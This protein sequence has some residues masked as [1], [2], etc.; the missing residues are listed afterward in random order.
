MD[1]KTS[2]IIQIVETSTSG[3]SNIGTSRYGETFV[4]YT[5]ASDTGTG[6]ILVQDQEGVE[7]VIAY[8]SHKFTGAAASWPA[9][10][11]EAYAI[12]MLSRSSIVICMEQSLKYTL[13]INHS[14]HC[15]KISKRIL[16][17]KGGPFR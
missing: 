12:L 6:G 2:R 11:K 16:S 5:D 4:L 14:G 9:I 15:F 1:R 7:K 3:G 8:V 13:T 10:G 17:C